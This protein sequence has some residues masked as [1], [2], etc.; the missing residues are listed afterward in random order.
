MKRNLFIV[1][2]PATRTKRLEFILK[3]MMDFC[4]ARAYK[5]DIYLTAQSQNAWKTVEKHFNETY[6]DL[7]I[8]GGDGTINEAV[9][10]LKFD[11]P[12]S[13]IPNG[14]GNDFVKM[15]NIGQSIEEQIQVIRNGKIKTIDLGVCNGRKFANGVGIGFDGQIVADMQNKKSILRGPAKYYF[16]VLRILATYKTRKF[17]YNRDK[18]LRQKDLI[19]LCVANGSTF[20]GSFKLTPDAELNDNMLDLCEIG[21]ISGLHRFLNIHRLQN[22]SHKTLKAVNI[23]QCRHITIDENPDLHA[24]IDGEYLGN[25]PFDIR[26]LPNA[27]KIRVKADS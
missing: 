4:A 13:I 23:S 6:T 1:A 9:N 5:F 7:V 21:Q 26:I 24:H 10:G 20:G 12:V 18:S 11:V 19:L 25:P 15:L 14:T 2:N 27:L 8:I 22:G 16:Y 3:E 17:R